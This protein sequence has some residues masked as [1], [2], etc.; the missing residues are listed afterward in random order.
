MT[1]AEEAIAAQALVDQF[2]AIVA[3]QPLSVVLVALLSTYRTTALLHPGSGMP[4]AEQCVSVGLELAVR[5]AE[6]QQPPQGAS[7]H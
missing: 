7:I 4:A 2:A 5:H 3:G 1:P 6:R